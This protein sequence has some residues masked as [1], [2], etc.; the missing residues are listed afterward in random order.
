MAEKFVEFWEKKGKLHFREEEEILLPAYSVHVPLENDQ[1]VIR[2]LADHALIRAKIAA[3]SLLLSKDE[4]IETQLSEL[5][6][7]VTESRKA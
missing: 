3:L 2:M 6:S 7:S 1:D 5:E 4:P